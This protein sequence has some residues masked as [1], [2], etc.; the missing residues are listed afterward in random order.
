MENTI[1]SSG[2]NCDIIFSEW[3]NGIAFDFKDECRD[4]TVGNFI[5]FSLSVSRHVIYAL[6]KN[7]VLSVISI[8]EPGCT[9]TISESR[10]E[11][12]EENV[13]H[14]HVTNYHG[15]DN[16]DS[17]MISLNNSNQVH[18]LSMTGR[19]QNTHNMTEGDQVLAVKSNALMNIFIAVDRSSTL[20]VSMYSKS[21]KNKPVEFFSYPNSQMVSLSASNRVVAILM[22]D[23]EHSNVSESTNF[24]LVIRPI[25]G[26]KSK[27][28]ETWYHCEN[29][30][31]LK[32]MT[33]VDN[34]EPSTTKYFCDENK[35]ICD[36][37]PTID[38]CDPPTDVLQFKILSPL[39]D[40]KSV[41][42]EGTTKLY[43]MVTLSILTLLSV[44]YLQ[45][46]TPLS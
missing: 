42:R 30:N 37:T 40:P 44:I 7:G 5:H 23:K 13:K 12:A 20:V 25:D 2:T 29:A 8:R 1:A 16:T 24:T 6:D 22:R 31:D 41:D 33:I 21:L 39:V 3:N 14:L 17:I 18:V 35:N 19:H 28:N 26:K 38:A 15:D 43:M 10:N 32:G 34:S 4:A 27:N 11:Y 45:F 36:R 9:F 46:I